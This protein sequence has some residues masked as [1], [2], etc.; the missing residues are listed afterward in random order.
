MC[1][2]FKSLRDFVLAVITV[3]F[4]EISLRR[5]EPIL[6]VHDTR[7]GTHPLHQLVI[8]NSKNILFNENIF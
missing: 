2:T 8:E 6:T 4:A 7:A 3:Y 1:L 5:G